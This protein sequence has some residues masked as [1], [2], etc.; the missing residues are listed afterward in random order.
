MY[1]FLEAVRSILKNIGSSNFNTSRVQEDILLN[2]SLPPP[3]STGAG[4]LSATGLPL[5][6]YRQGWMK[7]SQVSSIKLKLVSWGQCP[8]MYFNREYICCFTPGKVAR[9]SWSKGVMSD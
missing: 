2:P 4:S 6:E 8:K 3:I 1:A 7:D 9:F 5:S